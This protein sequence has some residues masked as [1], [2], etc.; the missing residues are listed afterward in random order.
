MEDLKLRDEPVL[1]ES[2]K[3]AV[4]TREDLDHIY[5]TNLWETYEFIHELRDFID[6]KYN[7]G[8]EEK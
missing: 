6:K 3:K 7:S 5:T 4:L 1:K 8:N 2:L